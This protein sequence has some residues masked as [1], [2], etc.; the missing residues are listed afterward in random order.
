METNWM[1]LNTIKLNQKVTVAC[2]NGNSYRT[3]FDGII[4]KI[5]KKYFYVTLENN[6][7]LRFDKYTQ[8]FA[9]NQ[10]STNE[11]VLWPSKEAYEEHIERQN[12]RNMLGYFFNQCRTAQNLNIDALNQI[13]DILRE[14]I[15]YPYPIVTETNKII[16]V[17]P[18]ND[19]TKRDLP[20]DYYEGQIKRITD[21]KF[22]VLLENSTLLKFNKD[23]LKCTYPFSFYK[24]YLYPN[25]FLYNMFHF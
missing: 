17:Q 6:R 23:T 5:G 20:K 11:A 12:K 18:A 22:E 19:L 2:Y 15:K 24:F 21:T 10:G 25:E 13:F 8:I 4:T 9:P 14:N 1:K 3:C 7:E 16:I